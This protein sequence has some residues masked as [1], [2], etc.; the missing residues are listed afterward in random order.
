MD[1]QLTELIIWILVFAFSVSF[2]EAAHAVAA[3]ALGDPT[4]K[5]KGRIS[6]NPMVHIDGLGLLF[7]IFAR[8]GWAKPVPVNSKNFDHPNLYMAITAAAGPL[9]NMF[10]AYISLLILSYFE[11][12]AGLP[13][14]ALDILGTFYLINVLLAAFN[15]IPLFPLDG[16]K[17]IS[18]FIPKHL[19][20]EYEHFSQY[21]PL[22]LFGA[23]GVGFV[24]NF[25]LLWYVL[26]P[27][28]TGLM[29]SLEY[30]VFF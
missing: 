13:K 16:E 22:I 5:M 3:Y 17:M 27:I 26:G 23:L 10:L 2:H 25:H 28:I 7:L 29:T 6:L 24:F 20:P 9:S 18:L 30:L 1:F 11:F 21:G 14:F 15:L 4:A 8:F 19:R 12:E